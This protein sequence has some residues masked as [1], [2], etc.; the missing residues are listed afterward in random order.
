MSVK[1]HCAVW[2]G[3]TERYATILGMLFKFKHFN[4]K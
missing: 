4:Y 3:G 2:Q 1:F